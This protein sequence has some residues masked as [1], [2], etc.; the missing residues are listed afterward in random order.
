MWKAYVEICV[1]CAL[2]S[3]YFNIDIANQINNTLLPDGLKL[4]CPNKLSLEQ[5]K[6]IFNHGTTTKQNNIIKL[7]MVK[8]GLKEQNRYG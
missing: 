6:G 4:R 3:K 7:D 5:T 1:I 2:C 8:T